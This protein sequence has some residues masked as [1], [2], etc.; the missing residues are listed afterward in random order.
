M[1]IIC[2]ACGRSFERS[3]Y[4]HH[5]R[6]SLNPQCREQRAPP[7]A[8]RSNAYS[9][10]H[11]HKSD[12]PLIPASLVGPAARGASAEP[13]EQFLTEF[14]PAGDFYGDYDAYGE[15]EFGM[16]LR[17]DD[18]G[19]MGDMAVGDAE[20]GLELEVNSDEEVE[21]EDALVAEQEAGLEP[22]RAQHHVD[23]RD[24]VKINEGTRP[25]FRLRGGVEGGL[26]SKPVVEKFRRGSAGKVFAS[27]ERDG[28]DHYSQSVGGDPENIYAPFRSQLEWEVAR[29]AKL[30]GPSSTAFTELMSIEGVVERLGL[31]FKSTKEL[32]KL[33]DYELPGRPPFVRHEIMVGDEVCDV[34]FRDVIA[35]ITALFGNPDF[36]PYLAFAPERHYSDETKTVRL[37]HDMKTG[38]WW[39][40]TQEQLEKDKPGATILPLIISTDKTQLTLFRNKSAYPIYLTIGNIPKE[41]RRKPSSRAYVLLG[42]LPTTRLENVSNKASRRRLLGNLYH[43]CMKKVLQPLEEAGVSGLFMTTGDGHTHRTHPLLACIVEDY[44]EQVLTTCVYTGECPV[45]PVHRDHLGDYDR[46]TRPGLRDI[47]VILKALDSFDDDPAGFLQTCA[48][49][50]IKP[51]VDPFWKDLPY[52]H[53]YRSITPDILHQLYQGII[54]HIIGWITE[55]IGAAEIDARCRRMPPNHNIRHFVK[56]ISSLSRVSGH[57]HDQMC[58]LLLGLVIDAPLPDGLSNVR[59]IRAVRAILDFLYLAQYPVHTDESLELLEDSLE[60]FHA[61]KDIFVD[62]GIRDGFNLPKLHFARHYVLAIKLFGTTDNVNT[63]YT[64]RLH[65]DLAKDAYAATNRKDEFS[66]MT[67]WLER[68]EQI[69]RHDQHINWRLAGSPR[70]QPQ[71]W[72]PPGL[73]LDRMLHITKQPTV[74]AVSIDKLVNAYGAKHFRTALARFAG[75]M[76]EPN[77]SA[78]QLEARLWGIHVP[79]CKLPVWHRVKYRRTDP[80]TG[81]TSTA[82]SIHAR[83]SKRLGDNRGRVVPGRF[84]TALINDG[85][86]EETGIEGYRIGRVRVVFSLPE[87]ARKRMFKPGLIKKK[88]P[89]RSSPQ[90]LHCRLL[91]HVVSVAIS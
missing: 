62:L 79:F 15:D 52:V 87:K 40:T 37:Y 88:H 53:I 41:I 30:Q 58:R 11:E 64:E 60:R 74:R 73:E 42:Y 17:A 70:P 26:S 5:I 9:D 59:L 18:D 75:A 43:A 8:S 46:E 10:S 16:T 6:Q 44:P 48:Q 32:N 89:G 61:N 2:K 12:I 27:E 7:T 21:E 84:D 63:Q 77:L 39:W 25:A 57:E 22:E 23:D 28:N 36:A 34:Y 13:L 24:A 80:F 68:K 38:K 47:D 1:R 83:P 49:I 55:A 54:K 78:A 65:I 33:I 4:G 14:D 69:L 45:C 91:P 50:G 86:G 76:N 56:G 81:V 85:T 71:E 31:S 19:P 82:D 3:G 90:L 72:D 66:Q 20:E 29:W 67:R 35:C 51:V